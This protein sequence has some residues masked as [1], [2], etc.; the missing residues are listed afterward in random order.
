M[1]KD[2]TLP[3]PEAVELLQS[4]YIYSKYIAVWS[5]LKANK[6]TIEQINITT[7]IVYRNLETWRKTTIFIELINKTMNLYSYIF[8]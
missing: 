4:I 6:C 5:H 1:V 7:D 8:I 3:A 2:D